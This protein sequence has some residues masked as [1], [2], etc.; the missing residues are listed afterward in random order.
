[1]IRFTK[2]HGLGNDFILV[3]LLQ[4]PSMDYQ[5]VAKN[6]CHRQLGIGGDGLVLIC[7]PENPANQL[8]M[9]IYNS[10]GSEADMCGNAIRC[11]A[12]YV[13][14]QGLVTDEEFRVETKAGVMIPRVLVVN[15][16]VTG[17]RVDMGQP[18]FR[19]DE[20]PVRLDGAEVVDREV[21][22][23]DGVYRITTVLMGN[24]HCVIFQKDVDRFPVK[25]VGPGIEHDPLFP[26]K[27]N[28]EFVE[29]LNR[30]E[31]KMRVWERG[32]GLTMACGTGACATAVACVK[33]G[34][35]DRH[36]IV[37][38]PGGDLE[39]E[40]AEDH[41]VYMTGPAAYVFTGEIAEDEYILN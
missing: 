30:Q 3:N 41:H 36:V 40:W 24:P 26:A 5:R 28:V 7:P 18:R 25:E 27:V 35:T 4:E 29:V 37:H 14:E 22:V 33:N 19:P 17:V 10:D 23:G 38:L 13:Y 15:Q 20:V 39:I 12:R 11:F 21:P 31:V 32:A 34:L 9:R 8:K 16:K 1:M 2:M 6:W